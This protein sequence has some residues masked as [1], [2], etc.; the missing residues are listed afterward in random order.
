MAQFLTLLFAFVRAPEDTKCCWSLCC[1]TCYVH[2]SPPLCVWCLLQEL[3]DLSKEKSDLASE[4][5]KERTAHDALKAQVEAMRANVAS[6]PAATPA[7]AAAAAG[8]GGGGRTTG[9]RTVGGR[10]VK[11]RRTDAVDEEMAG[12]QQYFSSL[13]A[14]GVIHITAG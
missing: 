11:R 9:G 10:S 4:L 14:R 13:F 2:C 5:F 12:E 8:G 1:T 3:A 6:P 7:A